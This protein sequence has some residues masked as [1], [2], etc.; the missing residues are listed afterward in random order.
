M[1]IHPTAIVHPGARLAEGVQVGA[2]SVIGEHV[3]IGEGTRIGPH[4]VVEGH[5]RIGRNNRIFQFCSI[6]SEPQDKKYAGEP[7]RLE[8]GDGNTIREFVT[9]NTGTVQDEGLTRIGHDCW[10]MAY[11]HIAHDCRLG[12]HIILANAVQ[13]AG[14]VHL[15]DWVF[16]GGLTGVHQFVKI[17]AHAM[18]GFASAINQDVPPFIM[19]DGNPPSAR[20][21]NIEGLRRR[22]FGPERIAAVKAMYR[23]IYRNG[24][25]LEQARDAIDALAAEHPEARED[26]AMMQAFLQGSTRGITR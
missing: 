12:D 26:V 19:A 20:G 5:T 13:L 18:I 24:L 17:G 15:G 14:H 9:I 4:V 10:I 3:E 11:V 25:T 23:Q 16:L 22:G 6:G 21:F 7:T 1:S 8:I 2:Y